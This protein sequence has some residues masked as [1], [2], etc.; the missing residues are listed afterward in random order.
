M[1]GDVLRVR[2]GDQIVV[3]GPLLDGAG[4]GRRVAAHR[5]VRPGG[6]GPRR[7]AA[8][9]SLCVGGRRPPAR[10][11][12]RGRELRRSAHRRGAPGHHR[13]HAAAAADRVR[14]PAGDRA[15]RADERGDPRP[16]RAGGVH[17][18]CASCRSR[19]CCPGWCPT[20][21][22]SSSRVAYT[23]GAAPHRRLRRA[24]AAGQRR[25]V[26]EQRRRRVHRQDRH[27]HHRAAHARRGRA[28]GGRHAARPRRRS[29]RSPAA[30]ARPNLTTAALAAAL[31]GEP[32]RS[33]T[34]CR[35]RS[36]LRWS[37]LVTDDGAL[38]ARRPDAL[39]PASDRRSRPTP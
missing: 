8:S 22:S 9:G 5:R 20:A 32:G 37:G 26:G 39:A 35:S 38:G 25:R 11:R 12:R 2:P 17:A 28:V 15:D 1:R 24:G 14:R 31:P 13:R 23:A 29:G 6:Q 16:G 33:A 34:R 30:S 18:C 36:S 19:R 27:A 4:R 10:P 3:D 21:C 7:R